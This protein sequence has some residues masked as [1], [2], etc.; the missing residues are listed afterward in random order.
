MHLEIKKDGKDTIVV[1]DPQ[2]FLWLQT[3]ANNAGN[4]F[5]DNW[6]EATKGGGRLVLRPL[7][8]ERDQLERAT[9]KHVQAPAAAAGA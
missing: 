8:P 7:Q 1:G 2:A 3:A 4:G 5:E 6:A 9:V